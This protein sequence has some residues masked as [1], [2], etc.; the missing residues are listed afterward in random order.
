MRFGLLRRGLEGSYSLDSLEVF[1]PKRQLRQ[2][3]RNLVHFNLLIEGVDSYSGFS[4]GRMKGTKAENV[5][6]SFGRSCKTPL[7]GS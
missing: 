4:S 1:D 2:F 7:D 6:F 3:I 5:Y